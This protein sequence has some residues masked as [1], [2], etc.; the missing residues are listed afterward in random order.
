MKIFIGV[1]AYDGKVFVGTMLSLMQEQVMAARINVRLRVCVLEGC[2]SIVSARNKLF[3]EFLRDQ[4]SEVMVFLDSD[5]S[6]G[7]PGDLLKIAMSPGDVV[8]AAYRYKRDEIKYCVNSIGVADDTGSV[9]VEPNDWG[10]VEV[11]A[12]GTGF[13]KISKKALY[14]IMEKF[15][16][17]W[18]SERLRSTSKL[19]KSD[20]SK[21]DIEAGVAEIENLKDTVFYAFCDMGYCPEDGIVWG[22]DYKFCDLAKKAGLKIHAVPEIE[23]SHWAAPGISYTGKWLD[24]FTPRES[25]T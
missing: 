19:G 14:I 13:L 18:S 23:I 21:E 1:P 2:S 22:E 10:G 7:A 11:G 4:D 20:G 9:K 6:W 25:E 24:T 15:P 5:I 12:L 8:G 17:R 16:N 3:D